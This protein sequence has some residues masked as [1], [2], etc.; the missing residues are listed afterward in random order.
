MR[1]KKIDY[2]GPPALMPYIDDIAAK[3]SFTR[4]PATVY[5]GD[6]VSTDGGL[7]LDVAKNEELDQRL[8]DLILETTFYPMDG[9][10]EFCNSQIRPI[11][12]SADYLHLFDT[13][14]LNPLYAVRHIKGVQHQRL[15][16]FDIDIKQLGSWRFD[17]KP[18]A[19]RSD[20]SRGFLK[21]LT[22]HEFG[23]ASYFRDLRESVDP[24]AYDRDEHG[25]MIVF[26]RHAANDEY[27]RLRRMHD[28]LDL[29]WLIQATQAAVDAGQALPYL[30]NSDVGD[31]SSTEYNLRQLTTIRIMG[32]PEQPAI[33]PK[34]AMNMLNTSLTEMHGFLESMKT[35]FEE[36]YTTRRSA[37]EIAGGYF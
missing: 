31:L 8:S 3:F 7:V 34:A 12:G 19:G 23:D 4:M 11:Q 9:I 30:E 25:N 13:I 26:M 15:S 32:N 6:I 35:I 36:A 24:T 1:E 17:V 18:E 5:V 28:R 2:A 27:H 37:A 21:A 16:V 29:G 14:M 33:N 22:E 20:L 10:E